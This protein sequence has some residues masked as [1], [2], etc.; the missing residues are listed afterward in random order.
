MMLKRK[1]CFVTGS[2][3]EYGLLYWLMKEVSTDPC[4]QIQIIATGMHLS[5]EFGLTYKV[6]EEDGFQ[7]DEKVE[8]LLSSDTATGVAKAIGLGV[9]G[10]ADSFA[11][12]CPDIVVVLGDRFEI[13]AVAQAAM[14]AQ[15]PVAHIHGGEVTEGA[16]DE[17][18]RHSISKMS[19]LH[20]TAAEVYRQR[21]IQLGE[22][23]TR[24]YNVGAVGLDNLVRLD[25]LSR[26]R[27]SKDLGFRLD[28]GPIILCTY[29]PVTL[30]EDNGVNALKELLHAL[31]EFPMARIVFTKSNAD[32]GGRVI[33]QMVDSYVD[34]NSARAFTH[35]NLGQVRYLSMLSIAD[36]VIGNSSSGILEAPAACTPTVDIGARQRGRL[37]APSVIHSEESRQSIVNAIQQSLSDEFKKITVRGLSPFGNGGASQKIKQVLKTV[38]LDNIV[39]KNFYDIQNSEQ[40][41]ES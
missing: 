21:V 32:S 2:R 23:P 3:A 20:F 30:C 28:G 22:H 11:R 40:I 31:D 4:L 29:H 35:T 5:P 15:I 13:F 16:V 19:H 7:I 38:A 10:F 12:L 6:I 34:D 36:L 41:L 39:F 26:E 37:R 33:N 18:I 1:I 25:L 24:V 8:T 17:A 14:A 9:I 27:L